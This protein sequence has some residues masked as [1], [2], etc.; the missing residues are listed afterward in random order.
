M[1][2][3]IA[4]SVVDHVD[5]NEQLATAVQNS[6]PWTF[7]REGRSPVGWNAMSMF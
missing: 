4:G 7:P 1:V 5:E 3:I 6:H 2:R